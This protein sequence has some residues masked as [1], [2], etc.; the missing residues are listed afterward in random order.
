MLF[1]DHTQHSPRDHVTHPRRQI[2]RGVT[3]SIDLPESAQAAWNAYRAMCRS[4]AEHIELLETLDHRE[5]A[6]QARTLAESHRLSQLLSVHDDAVRQFRTELKALMAAD[7]AG[8]QRMLQ[9]LQ[10]DAKDA[11]PNSSRNPI[12]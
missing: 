2:S 10:A 11:A 8:Y 3:L 12:Q 4:K 1:F 6:G 9:A 5:R 7:Q